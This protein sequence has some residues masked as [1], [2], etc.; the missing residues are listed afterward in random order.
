MTPRDVRQLNVVMS[1][2]ELGTM[3]HCAGEG[4]IHSQS[5]TQSV[6]LG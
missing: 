2:T 4:Q 3:N 5:V 1:P 6:R